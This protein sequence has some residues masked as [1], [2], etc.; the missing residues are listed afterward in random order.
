MTNIEHLKRRLKAALFFNKSEPPSEKNL[1]RRRVKLPE[2]T[3]SKYAI[4][5]LGD[6]HGN[7]DALLRAER[8]IVQDL[9]NLNRPG[10]V[11]YLGDYV[12]RG[13]H[14]SKVL[15]HLC[16]Q[17][18]QL[19]RRLAICGN[20]DDAFLNFLIDPAKSINWLRFGGADTLLSYGIDPDHIL[21]NGGGIAALS[22]IVLNSIP[23]NHVDF[24]RALPVTASIGNYVFVHAGIRPGIPID[25][26]TDEDLMWI[27]EPFLTEGP[28][29]PLTV[30]HGHTITREPIILNGRVGIDTGAFFTDHLAIIR[31]SESKISVLN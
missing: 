24:L 29:L 13:K 22:D 9:M 20:H 12:D 15:D 26:Q 27:R 7:F 25:K 19:F 11:V 4:Y 2:S 3:L 10:L 5:A 17:P 16:T 28:Q 23:K 30:V 8:I 21:K 31:I 6:V 18:D 1:R 14:S